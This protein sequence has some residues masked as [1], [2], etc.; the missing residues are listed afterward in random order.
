MDLWKKH[1]K[2]GWDPFDTY[3]VTI[4]LKDIVGGKPA[5]PELIEK[6]VAATNKAKSDEDR[7]RI[8]DA[9]LETL[10][11]VTGDKTEQQTTVFARVDGGLAIE[12]RQV[13]AMLKE[14]ANI[15]KSIGPD[16]IKNL[17][18]KVADQVFV[19]D[20][21]IPL[22]RTAPDQYLE[23]PIHVMTAQGPRTSIKRVEIVEGAEITFTIKRRRGKDKQSV[24]ETTLLAVLD[25][26]QT[27]GLG[28]DRSQG[29]GMFEV[30]SVEKLSK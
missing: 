5:S 17:R 2:S 20:E 11:E 15:I 8:V 23:R 19:A 9:H 3:R 21:Y 10:G 16:E 6:W 4:K 14:S 30:V 13:K 18:S 7:S 29:F 24:P 12:G 27:V 1:R 25:Y 22:G 26:A 28:A